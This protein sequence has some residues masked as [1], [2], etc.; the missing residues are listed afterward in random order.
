MLICKKKLRIVIRKILK[1][2]IE[3]DW[4]LEAEEEMLRSKKPANPEKFNPEEHIIT[5]A[6]SA[7]IMEKNAYYRSDIKILKSLGI[8]P[9]EVD[10]ST[11][12]N[13]G[14]FGRVYNVIYKGEQVVAKIGAD[15]DIPVWKK[16]ISLNIPNEYKKYVPEVK[17]FFEDLKVGKKV[18]VIEKLI[19]L[20]TSNLFLVWNH[21]KKKPFMNKDGPLPEIFNVFFKK[22]FFDYEDFV[23]YI[24]DDVDQYTLHSRYNGPVFESAEVN[25]RNVLS[26][27]EKLKKISEK[28]KNVLIQNLKLPPSLESMKKIKNKFK[29][30]ESTDEKDYVMPE[31]IRL[32]AEDRT[33]VVESFFKE[34]IKDFDNYFLESTFSY[35]DSLIHYEIEKIIYK[36]FYR[37]FP[38]HHS[39]VNYNHDINEISPEFRGIYRF[40]VWLRDH[41]VGWGDLHG[42]NVMINPK[43]KEI[44]IADVGMFD[45]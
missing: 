5:T 35:I 8:K 32:I 29:H 37:E 9:N 20:K 6:H 23:K 45:F 38:S 39:L 7:E 12:I 28:E 31:L 14:N 2:N 18:L 34:K 21:G 19:P 3:S 30:F 44:V 22:G 11:Y 4:D 40:L 24:V 15:D 16:I 36:Y 13:M 33:Q 25:Y 42:N 10:G 41:G 26:V 17:A 27:V 43:T 1:E